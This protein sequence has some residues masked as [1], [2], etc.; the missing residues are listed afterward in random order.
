VERA[1]EQSRTMEMKMESNIFEDRLQAYV[2]QVCP[3]FIVQ[4]NDLRR[5]GKK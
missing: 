4:L 5:Q 3:R 1:L 2:N